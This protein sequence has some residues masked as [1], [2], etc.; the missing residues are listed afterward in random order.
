MQSLAIIDASTGISASSLHTIGNLKMRQVT[1]M[2]CW[3]TRDLYNQS[4]INWTIAE[5]DP[6]ASSWETLIDTYMSRN[7]FIMLFHV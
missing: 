4:P 7:G 2:P 5:Q 6:Q 3:N 1:P